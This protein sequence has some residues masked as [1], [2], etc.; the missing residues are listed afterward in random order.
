VDRYADLINTIFHPYNMRKRAMRFHDEMLP[1]MGRHFALWGGTSPMAPFIGSDVTVSDWEAQIDS[2][3]DFTDNRPFY[4]RNH[5]EYDFGL[6]KQVNVTLDVSPAG[7]GKIRISTIIPDSLPWTGVYFDGVPVTM[8]AIANPGY[9]F[10]QWQ[11]PVLVQNPVTTSAMTL[12]ISADDAFTAYFDAFEYN[13][14]IYPN[15]FS[16]VLTI[17]YEI[18]SDKQVYLKLYDVVGR[19][20]ADI[21]PPGSF[22]AEGTH[23][24]SFDPNK[25]SLADGIYFLKLRTDEFSKTEKIIRSKK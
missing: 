17:N 14:N 18:P 15:P 1:E 16:D 20:V 8:T 13:M 10:R 6:V 24:I 7:A 19:L 11:S 5:I 23:T 12:N 22:Q 4:A 2:L 3:F 21:V 25:Y 9:K